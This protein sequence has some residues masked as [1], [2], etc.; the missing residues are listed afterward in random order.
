[1]RKTKNQKGTGIF[2]ALLLCLFLSAG[3]EKTDIAQQAVNDMLKKIG[4]LRSVQFTLIM[5]ERIKD[6][7]TNKK[8][9][10]KVN[11]SPFKVYLKQEY[12]NRGMEILYIQGE[13]RNRALVNLNSFPYVN[14]NL[15]PIGNAMRSSHHNSVLKA[16][17]E[18]LVKIVEHLFS[19]YRNQIGEMT[20][21][22][23]LVKYNGVICY[24]ITVENPAFTYIDYTVQENE[25]L[26]DIS[27]KLFVSDFMIME[28]NPSLKSFDDIRPGIH[29]KVPNDYAKTIILYID[30]DKKIPVGV[31]SFDE[32]GLFNEYIYENV[33]LN[34]SFGSVDF[35]RDNPAYHF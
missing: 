4:D 23:G 31:K 18:F 12:P 11:Y 17:F 8:A 3:H 13:N 6:E 33:L 28:L 5:K 30:R 24:K 22:N 25:T 21:Y 16:G 14:L 9:D 32:K 2:S 34:P 7:I 35:D 20:T 19:K 27:W 26:E 1:M 10:F 29:L 15:D